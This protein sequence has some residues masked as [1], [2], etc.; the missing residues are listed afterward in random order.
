MGGSLPTIVGLWPECARVEHLRALRVGRRASPIRS[1]AHRSRSSA[2]CSISTEGSEFRIAEDAGGDQRASAGTIRVDGHTPRGSQDSHGFRC[3][4]GFTV[5]THGS[6]GMV[7]QRL[8]MF[9]CHPRR[10]PC[11][12]AS[13]RTEISC[14]TVPVHAELRPRF[15]MGQMSR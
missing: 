8:E 4:G 13:R 10:T 7:Q 15:W 6:V 12:S 5:D 3:D 14:K 11:G 1:I 9:H 2:H